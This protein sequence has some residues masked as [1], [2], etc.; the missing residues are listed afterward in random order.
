MG[1]SHTVSWDF[2]QRTF[3]RA[4]Q[5]HISMEESTREFRE[6]LADIDEWRKYILKRQS[7]REC[8][9]FLLSNLDMN[10]DFTG[11]LKHLYALKNYPSYE[12][13]W[14]LAGSL[15]FLYAIDSPLQGLLE[16]IEIEG[17]GFIGRLDL[18][19]CE[20]VTLH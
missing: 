18:C 13:D 11:C 5:V 1:F 20:T 16:V 4:R 15:E 10:W 12:W 14:D 6:A 17:D 9:S 2:V 3:D 8:S 7:R 19:W